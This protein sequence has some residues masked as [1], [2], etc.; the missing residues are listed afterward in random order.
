MAPRRLTGSG[1]DSFAG[2]RARLVDG[3]RAKGIADLAVLK[4]FAE[5]PRHLFVPDALRRQAYDDVALP[6]GSG[7]T[8]SQPFTQARYL[9]ALRLSGAER[10]LEVGTGS[11]YQTALLGA[12]AEQVFSVELVTALALRARDVLR[13]AGVTNV[14]VLVGDGTL[15]WSDYAPY[16]AILVAAGGPEVPPP[17]VEQLTARGRLL[18]PLGDR[19]AQVLT[20]VQRA[21]ADLRRT[22]LG[23]A[24]FVPLLGEHGFDA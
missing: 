5:T 21:G 22:P 24:R 6:I 9:E 2:Y 23:D 17:L 10:V 12:L 20:L 3:L 1:G 7:Q 15:G 19:G 18:I 16:D 8:I 13:E 14:S 4:A 11:G